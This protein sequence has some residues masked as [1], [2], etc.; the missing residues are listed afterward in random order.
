MDELEQVKV[1]PVKGGGQ[2]EVRM[3][4]A[5]V[6]RVRQ[7]FGLLECQWLE[8]EHVAGYVLGA[9]TSAVAKAE[10]QDAQHA[11]EQHPEVT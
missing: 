10:Q 2:L 1:I 4:Q 9:L 3:T 8:D 11:E 7:H 5:F 6:A